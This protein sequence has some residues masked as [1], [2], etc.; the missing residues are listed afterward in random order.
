MDVPD[1]WE[2]KLGFVVHLEERMEE[3]GFSETELRQMLEEATDLSPSRRPGRWLVS[4]RFGGKRWVVVVEPD[5][6]EQI[7]YVVTAYP[8]G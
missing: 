2:W 5:S 6:V 1:W 3:R 4:T 8:R 7:T